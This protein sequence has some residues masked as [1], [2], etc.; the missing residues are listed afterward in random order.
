MLIAVA[1]AVWTCNLVLMGLAVWARRTNAAW[2]REYAKTFCR[3][4]R[5]WRTLGYVMIALLVGTLLVT[6]RPVSAEYYVVLL[7]G[8]YVP[9]RIG[10]GVMAMVS[11][12]AAGE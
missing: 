6:R 3:I 10:F 5:S 1:V 2:L 4:D 8:V 7:V 12:K 9:F 11:A